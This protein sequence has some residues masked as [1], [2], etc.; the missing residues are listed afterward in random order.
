MNED[1][2]S[3][4][5]GDLGHAQYH[6]SNIKYLSTRSPGCVVYMPPEYLGKDAHFTD[7]GDTFS[8]GVV[9]LEVF[10]QEPPSCGLMNIGA[11]PETERRAADLAKL[12]NFHPLKP[13]IIRC[14][15]GFPDSRPC[16]KEIRDR[17]MF[18]IHNPLRVEEPISRGSY[19]EVFKGT[20][21]ARPV[22]IKKIHQILLD[23]AVDQEQDLET[24]LLAFRRECEILKSAKDPHIVEFFGVYDKEW[25]EDGEYLVMELMHQTLDKFLKDNKGTLPIE[26]QVDICYQVS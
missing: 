6:P 21:G 26:K 24:I 1:G 14:L 4:K 8:L 16:A 22:A 18:L 2:S 9:M 17:L 13:L 7:K 3:V 12:S 10:I 23:A 15:D 25:E 19:G 20:L 11:K 5:I